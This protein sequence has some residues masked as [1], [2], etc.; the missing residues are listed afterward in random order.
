MRSVDLSP[1]GDVWI[2][3]I[4]N[5]FE[6][7]QSTDAAPLT[8]LQDLYT[9]IHIYSDCA[10]GFTSIWTFCVTVQDINCGEDFIQRGTG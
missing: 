3:Y 9:L 6:Q 8:E 1:V 5:E 7:R 2:E 10:T 4:G